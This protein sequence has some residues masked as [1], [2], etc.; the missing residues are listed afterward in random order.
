MVSVFSDKLV[1]RQ[2]ERGHVK[3]AHFLKQLD[4]Y[5]ATEDKS[6]DGAKNQ[7]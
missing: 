6:D 4:I 3:V 7:E 1:V 2:T 5:P